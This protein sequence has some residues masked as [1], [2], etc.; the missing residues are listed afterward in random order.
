MKSPIMNQINTVFVH[1]SNL[2]ESV[3]WYSELLGLEYDLDMVND[4]VYN[5]SI[6]QH[7]GL[8]L[9]AGP[10]DR[11]KDSNPSHYPLFNFHT[12]NIDEAWSYVEN[13]GY[14]IDSSIIRFDDFSFF[15]IKDLDGNIIMIC[16]G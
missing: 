6:N 4:P 13:M 9:D 15:T 7:T 3:R 11:T 16:T 12:E 8:T 10:E 5:I 2:K 1:V 14:D